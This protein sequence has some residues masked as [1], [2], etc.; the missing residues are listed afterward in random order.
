MVA[1]GGSLRTLV[2]LYAIALVAGGFG[3]R[4]IRRRGALGPAPPP[5]GV[6]PPARGAGLEAGL[7]AIA[8][9]CALYALFAHRVDASDAFAVNLAVAAVDRPELPLLAVDTLHGRGDLPIFLPEFRLH[10]LELGYA[11]LAWI[12]GVQP[13]AVFHFAGAALGAGALPL[14]H[15]ALL[16]WLAPRHWIALVIALIVLLAAVGDAPHG[17]GNTALL[18]SWQ[19]E[20]IALFVFVP[21]VYAFAIRFA[22]SPTGRHWALLAAAQVGALGCS[23]A[24]LWAAPLAAVVG[25]L[26]ALPR[27]RERARRAFLGA[28]ASA[29]LPAAW[30][31]LE[32]GASSPMPRPSLGDGVREVLGGDVFAVF[33]IAAAVVA[34]ARCPRG[35]ARRFAIA[36]PLGAGLVALAPDVWAGPSHARVLGA[37]PAPLLLSLALC[38]A[39]KW[40]DERRRAAELAAGAVLVLAVAVFVPARYGWSAENHVAWHQPGLRVPAEAARWERHVNQRAPRQRVLASR[41]VSTWI[42]VFRDHAY[43][44]LVRDYLSPDRAGEIAYGDRLVM[45]RYATGELASDEAAAVFARG[46]DLYGVR[47]VC[48]RL[49]AQLAVQRA[50]LR[51]HGFRRS[52]RGARYEIWE[53][54][55]AATEPER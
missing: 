32:R 36:V 53:R 46:L 2:A 6:E 22:L 45:T 18:A 29:Y 7:W 30:F 41:A 37:F 51:E 16:R 35:I 26:S 5:A 39:P 40:I 19:G 15:A 13:I 23:A 52:L 47:L 50:A 43:P 24:A 4:G 21:L 44:L 8:A 42:P 3:L 25:M 28:L 48:L 1:A 55:G 33:A 54:A 38:A 27:D 34:W 10:S 12:F 49:S 14:A 9:L 17:Y 11:A 31:V 20:A